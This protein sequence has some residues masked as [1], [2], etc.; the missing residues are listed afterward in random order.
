VTWTLD[1]AAVSFL[2]CILAT[3]SNHLITLVIIIRERFALKNIF[4]MLSSIKH[5]IRSSKWNCVEDLNNKFC[6]NKSSTPCTLLLK[7]KWTE[8]GPFHW[9]LNHLKVC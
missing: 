3:M 8:I 6:K 9:F 1:F 7:D 2:S 4:V 5:I